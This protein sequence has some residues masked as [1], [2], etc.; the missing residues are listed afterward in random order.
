MNTHKL[1]EELINEL[2]NVSLNFRY[3]DFQYNPKTE[4][5]FIN[6]LFPKYRSYKYRSAT[7][8]YK[9]ISRLSN[10]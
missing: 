9:F 6:H 8:F 4:K 10:Q 1:K 3:F 7:V 2:E 5:E